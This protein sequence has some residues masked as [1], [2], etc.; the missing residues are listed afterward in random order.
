[1]TE[2]D[3]NGTRQR[4]DG[5]DIDRRQFVRLAAA[6]AGTLA[7]PG[8]ATAQADSEKM[9][10]TYRFVVNH[11]PKDERIPTLAT[12]D[13]RS[14]IEAF[15][16][17]ADSPTTTTSPTAAAYGRLTTEQAQRAAEIDALS[18]LQFSPGSNPFWKLEAYADGIFPD[19]SDA[20]GFIDF[21]EMIQG[22]ERLQD[23]HS[24]R[25]RFRSVGESPG[26]F[27]LVSGREEPKPVWV[28][29]VTNAVGDQASFQQKEKVLFS[30]SIHGDERAGAEAGCRFIESL[31]AGE[32]QTVGGLLDDVALLFVF[33]NPDGWVAKY[34]QYNDGGTG[35]QRGSA[36]VEDTNRS[37]PTVGWLDATHFPAET[38]GS[39]LADDYPGIDAD[40]GSEYTER[41]PD[42][43]GIVEHFRSYD[44]LNYGSDLHGM[45]A[46]EH[47]IEGLL[48]N[49]QFSVG[50]LHDLYEVNRTTQKR[51]EEAIGQKVQNRQRL[52]EQ[53]NAQA[54][55]DEELP[56]PQSSFNY[57]TVYD[58]LEY[59]TSGILVSWM[60][61][62][63]DQGGLGMK[64]MAHEMAYSNDE[65]PRTWRPTEE[66]DADVS[67]LVD[68]FVD[69]YGTVIR[70]FAEHAARDHSARIE[71]SGRSTA[72]STT[73]SL[74]RTS[75]DLIHVGRESLT[76]SEATR[77]TALTGSVVEVDGARKAL[78]PDP[79]EVIGYE[80]RS[81]AVSPF[82]FFERTEQFTPDD[83]DT[84]VNLSV[85]RIANAGLVGEDGSPTH[86][87]VVVTHDE[88]IDNQAY[89]D[90]L[91]AFVESGGNLVLTDTG[92]HLLGRMT[93]GLAQ[94]IAPADVRTE[95]TL[96]AIFEEDNYPHRLLTD[97]R[98]FNDEIW[99]LAPLG[100]A[101]QPNAGEAP[102]TLVDPDAFTGAGG[103]V[104]ART[105]GRVAAGSI[106]SSDGSAGVH[107]VGTLLPPAKQTHLHPFGMVDHTLSFF[108]TLVL[109]NALGYRQRRLVDG[110]TVRTFGPD[111][112]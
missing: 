32:E 35:Y 53:L 103:D 56:T 95:Q 71:T 93:N 59:S 86:A 104:A 82:V 11:T 13:G 3:Q 74:T 24:D 1:M 34:P 85:G 101:I 76:V 36:G 26:Y 41:V 27:N 92:V 38:A 63:V 90:S 10:E 108:G 20:V 97:T 42:A 62:P 28:A 60:A 80:Q 102:I 99:K 75:R 43:L 70:T 69:G 50:E 16:Q 14:G 6:T 49:D 84:F 7:L 68:L 18:E 83:E 47:M 64:A 100:Y 54:D 52:F 58:T 66:F 106:T 5:V 91:D 44:N 30:L 105:S 33:T 111:G 61:Q 79:T 29:E 22:M 21:Q 65:T 15:S 57:G 4:F 25:L 37:Y 39:N 23:Q 17:V 55:S 89:V 78:T 112:G 19:P 51:L 12:F 46:S 107:V 45:Y 72:V 8:A 110:E 98:E 48:I 2:R 77:E 96:F 94:G 88:G 9:T 67:Q 109:T 73:D 87:N 40:V 81:Y 31:L